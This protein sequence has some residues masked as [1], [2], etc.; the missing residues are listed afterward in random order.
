L[1]F[2]PETDDVREAPALIMIAALLGAGASVRAYD[3]KASHEAQRLLGPHK[4]I[5][6]V[7]NYYEAAEGCDALIIATEWAFFR[8]PDFDRIHGALKA[9]VI[10]DGRNIYPLPLM[11]QYGFDYV[12]IGRDP[13]LA[14]SS[15]RSQDR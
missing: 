9:P 5:A 12:S 15:P 10:F 2:N 8:N 4:E 13:V 14:F 3:P 1:A 11:R 6:Y 7:D